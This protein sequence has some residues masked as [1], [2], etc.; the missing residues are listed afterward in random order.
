MFKLK[1]KILFN[2]PFLFCL[3]TSL[4]SQVSISGRI[5][6]S[7]GLPIKATIVALKQKN[8]LILSFSSSDSNGKYLLKAS[9]LFISDSL[10]V[11]SSILG[12]ANQLKRV[13]SNIE[14]INFTLNTIDNLLPPVVV[15]NDVALV[16]SKKDTI[17]YNVVSFTSTRDRFIGDVLK[18]IPGVEMLNDGK[19]LFQGNPISKIYLDGDDLVSRSYNL[20]TN[21]IPVDFISKIQVLENFQEIKAIKKLALSNQPAINLVLSDKAK[22]KISGYADIGFGIPKLYD[23]NVQS[24]LFKKNIKFLNFIKFNNIGNDLKSDIV[25]QTKGFFEEPS[26]EPLVR[27]SSANPLLSNSRDLFNK[28][29][30]QVINGLKKLGSE[31]QLT[32]NLFRLENFFTQKSGLKRSIFLPNDTVRYAENKQTNTYET[33][34]VGIVNFKTNKSNYF[35]SNTVQFEYAPNKI[36]ANMTLLP[37]D[38]LSQRSSSG[39]TTFS[40]DIH[41]IKGIRKR[42]LLEGRSYISVNKTPVTFE[43]KPALVQGFFSFPSSSVMGLL[44]NVQTGSLF[45]ENYISLGISGKLVQSYKLG[46]VT[47]R[48]SL[49]SNLQKIS[50]NGLS[51]N[52]H[53]SVNNNITWERTKFYFEP[54]VT[55]HSERLQSEF[56][57]S[58]QNQFILLND[59][60][61]GN[62][63]NGFYIMPRAN[64]KLIIGKEDYIFFNTFYNTEFGTVRNGYRNFIMVDYRSLSR[65]KG[66][67]AESAK[68][69]NSIVYHHRKTLKLLFLSI[70]GTYAIN[71]HNSISNYYYSPFS[72]TSEN[73]QVPYNNYQYTLFGSISKYLFPLRTT[74]SLNA[75]VSTTEVK[76]FQN[77]QLAGFLNTENEFRYK[78]DSKISEKL[79]ASY[80][81]SFRI[82]I[83]KLSGSNENKIEILQ[84][85]QTNN[86][87]LDLVYSLSESIN[88]RLGAEKFTT[89][90]S[91]N[92]HND[93][94]FLDAD[95]TFRSK[96]GKRDFSLIATNILNANDYQPISLQSNII[97]LYN[98]NLR[99]SSISLKFNLKF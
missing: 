31:S 92:A 64:T 24:Q 38:I 42:I 73:I 53:D 83:N 36:D 76:Q 7:T 45:Q 43:S 66:L 39:L 97:D 88:C 62:K 95:L 55:I 14:T 48:Q 8:G 41:I 79:T 67:L 35:F 68:F 77:G 17:E 18:K 20:I 78:L 5:T 21:N 10:F 28:S 26:A 94:T 29:N 70:G 22:I 30:I 87:K 60:N 49:N 80:D 75:S 23:G 90:L 98:Y 11:E 27:L 3:N 63:Q 44:Q 47:E 25:S 91:P 65:N 72:I 56:A 46:L 99:P 84:R 74:F 12:Y 9:T 58:F 2:F 19:I 82:F 89:T 16:R 71:S 85:G 52:I 50:L 93:L 34:F 4:F 15:T 1:D 57:V 61:F 96:D 32:A 6:D 81:G 13:T 33:D 51:E 59:R 86:Q 40:N 69:S 37:T 54:K